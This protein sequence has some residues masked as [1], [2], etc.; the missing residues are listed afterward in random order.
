MRQAHH[1]GRDP[2]QRQDPI[3]RHVGD[4][5]PGHAGDQRLPQVLDEGDAAPLLDGAQPG[6]AV[7]EGAREDHAYRAGRRPQR[8]S[9]RGDRL[10]APVLPG[11]ARHAHPAPLDDQVMVWRSHIN[12]AVPDA[13]PILP[14]PLRIDRI[15]GCYPSS[16]VDPRDSAPCTRDARD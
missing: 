7:V 16:I 5:A 14:A 8:Q 3:N 11:A 10:P 2:M 12:V 4:G 15:V 13:P 9:G 6:R 1:L